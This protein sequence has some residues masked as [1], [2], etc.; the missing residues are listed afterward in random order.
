MGK[1]T[2][3]I[4]GTLLVGG[5]IVAL[6]S[7][8]AEETDST[9]IPGCTDPT[10]INYMPSA[11]VDNGR[12]EYE[13]GESPEEIQ[14]EEEEE[15]Q[16]LEAYNECVA[17]KKAW[18]EDCS[19]LYGL[20]GARRGTNLYF[21]GELTTNASTNSCDIQELNAWV[22]IN[23]TKFVKGEDIYIYVGKRRY[24]NTTFSSPE[25]QT[26]CSAD[27]KH[28]ESMDFRIGVKSDDGTYILREYASWLPSGSGGASAI[29]PGGSQL[30][31]WK[32]L[33]L[34]TDNLSIGEPVNFSIE[35][36]VKR[37]SEGTC[38]GVID[39]IWNKEGVFTIYPN[40]CGTKVKQDCDTLKEAESYKAEWNKSHQSFMS[41]WV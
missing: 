13:E 8:S 33:V 26:W 32:R 36:K 11:T 18:K 12:C 17:T 19:G 16:N 29:P 40:K 35:A 2:G 34:K 39:D 24:V 41:E 10:A 1:L 22:Y 4:V 5:A 31:C 15:Q 30:L 9:P 37:G 7:V 25:W 3:V 21:V 27:A 28:G 38:I 23:K 20:T 6:G 14:E